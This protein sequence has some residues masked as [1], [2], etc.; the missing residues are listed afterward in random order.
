MPLQVSTEKNQRGSDPNEFKRFESELPLYSL[1][2]FHQSPRPSSASLLF[3]MPHAR[4]PRDSSED[5]P[6]VPRR[7]LHAHHCQHR[8][9]HGQ[10]S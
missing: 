3:D 9:S 8:L 10:W 4:L 2:P 6:G 7:G 1:A 5:P